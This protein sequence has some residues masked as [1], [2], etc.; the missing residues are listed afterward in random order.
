MHKIICRAFGLS[1]MFLCFSVSLTRAEDWPRWLGK[2]GDSTWDEKSTIDSFPENKDIVKWRVPINAG[3][4]GPAVADGRVFVMDRQARELTDEEKAVE[5]PA[6]EFR[7]LPGNERVLCLDEKTGKEIWSHT[8]DRDYKISY[9]LGPRTTP[10]VDGNRVYTL[11]AMG[12]L[13]CFNATNGKIIWQKELTKQ[14]NTKPPVWG[15]SAHLLVDGEKL[16]CLVGAKDAGCVAFNKNDG[17]ELWRAIDAEEIC[18]APPVIYENEMSRQ[19]L[20]WYDVAI[21]SLDPE[22]GKE[23]WT[24]DF[25]GKVPARPAVTIVAPRVENNMLMVSDFY[26]G[27]LM[28]KLKPAAAGYEVMWQT[29]PEDSS[30]RKFMNTLMTTPVISDGFIYGVNGN[31]EMRCLDVQT[32]KIIWETRQPS[33]G[34]LVKTNLERK[35]L[36]ATSF[37]V[38]NN[39]KFFIFNDQ[40]YL[41]IAKMTPKGYEELDRKSFLEPSSFARGRNIVWA[42]PAFANGHMY[43]RND[44]E[45]ICVDLQ[46]PE[47]SPE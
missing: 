5:I 30:Q 29:E 24:C 33:A 39:D 15:Y 8:Y 21:K 16:I 22:T 28:I 40:G 13:I 38:E 45:M 32:G 34:D 9:P 18:Y 44:K 41:I 12:D 31:G 20:V 14:Y 27:S 26:N 37:I 4:S 6:G 7:P 25:P 1:M 3:Y 47:T 11:G 42:H 43:A 46:K 23:N 36:F 17:T 35:I 10:Y 19:L 2:N